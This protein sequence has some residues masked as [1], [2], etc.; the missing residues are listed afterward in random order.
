[1]QKIGQ[2][3][4]TVFSRMFRNLII[5]GLVV[6]AIGT[7]WFSITAHRLPLASEWGLVGGLTLVAG[8]LGAMATLV[9]ELSHIGQISR[10]VRQG[11]HPK[12][13]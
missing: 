12:Q 10:A 13:G 9:W 3:I 4:G 11:H 8:L 2:T 1:M 5:V 7:A 6:G